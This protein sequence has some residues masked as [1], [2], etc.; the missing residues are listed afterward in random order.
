MTYTKK[1]R[2]LG[3]LGRKR[4]KKMVFM[5]TLISVVFFYSCKKNTLRQDIDFENFPEEI[6]LPANSDLFQKITLSLKNKNYDKDIAIIKISEGNVY[7]TDEV[8]FMQ[9][10]KAINVTINGNQVDFYVKPSESPKDFINLNI[11]IRNSTFTLPVKFTRLFPDTAYFEFNNV[12]FDT[13]TTDVNFSVKLINKNSSKI[14]NNLNIY[15]NIDSIHSNDPKNVCLANLSPFVNATLET[16]LLKAD[17]VLHNTSKQKGIIYL[18][19][20]Y[21]I[22]RDSFVHIKK[23]ITWK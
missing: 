4:E 9:E 19:V 12:V 17:N 15:F 21:Q 10:S 1:H 6:S 22:K 16:N 20:S 7:K 8:S 2:E 13:N 18:N 5:L 14:S 23:T 11:S 3:N